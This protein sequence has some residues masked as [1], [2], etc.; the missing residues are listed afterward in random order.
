M[1]SN[2]IER[3]KSEQEL[4]S[5]DDNPWENLDLNK[6]IESKLGAISDTPS[7]QTNKKGGQ[8]KREKQGKQK[9]KEESKP[10]AQSSSQPKGFVTEGSKKLAGGN[11]MNSNG[12]GK[13]EE[14][15]LV[16]FSHFG[17][18]SDTLMSLEEGDDGKKFD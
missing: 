4:E 8:K 12:K 15:K 17:E 3:L 16:K 2:G 13:V 1:T 10:S 7:Q 9:N 6:K 11:S 18:K 14:R 5:T